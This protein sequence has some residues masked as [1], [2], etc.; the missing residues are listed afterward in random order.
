MLYVFFDVTFLRRRP[1]ISVIYI[2]NTKINERISLSLSL[3]IYL[4]YICVYVWAVCTCVCIPY[5]YM[6]TIYICVC[7]V[8]VC[9]R[10]ICVHFDAHRYVQHQRL[11]FYIL[12][13]YSWLINNADSSPPSH[14]MFII[15]IVKFR[16]R[17]CEHF[18]ICF[19]IFIHR[20]FKRP[21]AWRFSLELD[22][23]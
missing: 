16:Y 8:Y 22:L 20:V 21:R 6:R 5:Y 13:D 9:M 18:F 10:E 15:K 1:W 11:H 7:M 17:N 12:N 14:F 19:D 3:S 23:F 4:S 2:S